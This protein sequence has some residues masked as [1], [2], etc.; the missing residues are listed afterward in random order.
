MSSGRRD[1]RSA[2]QLEYNKANPKV[3][4]VG[5]PFTKAQLGIAVKKG[6]KEL[7]DLTNAVLKELKNR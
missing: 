2:Q 1:Q 4:I 7:L 3:K 6:D 5:E